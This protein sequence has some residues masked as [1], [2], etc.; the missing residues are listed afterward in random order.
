MTDEAALPDVPAAPPQ[1]E[2][3]LRTPMQDPLQRVSR[4][5][6]R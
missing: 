6:C 5:W 4:R 1:G 2:T 3:P